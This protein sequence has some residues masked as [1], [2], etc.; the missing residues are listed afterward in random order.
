MVVK[1]EKQVGGYEIH[2]S[3]VKI[4]HETIDYP[5]SKKEHGV[6]FL[7]ENRHLWLRSSKQWAI[8]RV[9]NSIIFSIHNFFQERGFVQMD[10]PIFTGN[11]VEGT[12]TLFATDFYD[13]KAYLSQSGQP[14]HP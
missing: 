8:M 11:A 9:R 3:D 7:M 5:I 6:D 12:T 13:E 2:V 10:S 14:L 4:Y 1:D